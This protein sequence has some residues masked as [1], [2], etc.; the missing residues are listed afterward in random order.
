MRKKR[1]KGVRKKVAGNTKTPKLSAG[2]HQELFQ[3]LTEKVSN[4]KFPAGKA[5]IW[6]TSLKSEQRASLP[7]GYGWTK[8][9]SDWKPVWSL[10]PETAS[11]CREL[12][13]CGCQT[14]LQCFRK[15]RCCKAAGFLA[16]RFTSAAE[17]AKIFE[18]IVSLNQ[19]SPH[20]TVLI[21]KTVVTT[22]ITV[23]HI[24]NQ[25]T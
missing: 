16:Q 4:M 17:A 23:L 12:L 1:G 9:A 25:D 8:V 13:E 3:L 2:S 5:S 7:E 21:V 14:L 18:D 24:S 22:N 11:V 10:I 6:T 20:G 19:F 15:C